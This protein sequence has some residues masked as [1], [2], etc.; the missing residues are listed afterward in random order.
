MLIQFDFR[1]FRLLWTGSAFL[2]VSA[3]A[4]SQS[5]GA[6]QGTVTDASGAAVPKPGEGKGPDHGVDRAGYGFGGHLLCAFAAGWN[7]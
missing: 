4:F 1:S 7:L 6:I 3:F 2:F 5:T